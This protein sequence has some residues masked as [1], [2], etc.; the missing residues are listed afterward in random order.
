MQ[1]PTELRAANEALGLSAAAG[2]ESA[3]DAIADPGEPQMHI[4][5]ICEIFA[6]NYVRA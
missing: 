6:R 1:S 5:A 3:A 2:D 4:D